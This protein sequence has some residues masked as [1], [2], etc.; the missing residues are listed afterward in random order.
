[1]NVAVRHLLHLFT[2][3]HENCFDMFEDKGNIRVHVLGLLK[4]KEKYFLVKIRTVQHEV[5]TPLEMPLLSEV[6][7]LFR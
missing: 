1:M 7:I 2:V 5:N 6:Q 4:L 3:K